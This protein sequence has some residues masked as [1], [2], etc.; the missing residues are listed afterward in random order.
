MADELV[1]YE[2]AAANAAPVLPPVLA[3]S[4]TPAVR[5]R[6]EDFYLS[7]ATIFETWVGRRKSDHTQRAY[8]GDVMAFVQFMKWNWPEDATN[9]LRTSI[10]DVQAFKAAIVKHGGA[11]KTI[12]RRV[13]SLSSFYKYLAGAAAELCLPITVP[14]PAHSQF[15]SRESSDPVEETRALSAARAHQLMGFPA[16]GSV[17]ALRDRAIIKF[18]VLPLWLEIHSCSPL[19]ITLGQNASSKHFQTCDFCPKQ[20]ILSSGPYRWGCRGVAEAVAEAAVTG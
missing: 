4:L 3:G 11:P 8:R 20:D 6:V 9:M 19:D 2:G 16:G 10:L 13:S 15:I 14:N 12:N 7:V 1:R 17:F 5:E 18:Y